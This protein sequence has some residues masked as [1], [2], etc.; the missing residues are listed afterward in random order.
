[1]VSDN[2]VDLALIRS[3]ALYCLRREQLVNLCKRH[4]I[5]PKGKVR[6][7]RNTD[8]STRRCIAQKH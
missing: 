6:L 1:M 7:N 4:G 2:A 3:E 8:E 5:K